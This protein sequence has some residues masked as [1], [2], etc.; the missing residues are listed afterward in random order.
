MKIKGNLKKMFLSLLAAMIFVALTGISAN[1]QTV[2]YS[3]LA[4]FSGAAVSNGGAAADPANGANLITRL[5]ADDLTMTGYGNITAFRF[6]VS[7]LGATAVSARPRVRF[8]QANGTNG[9]PGTLLGGY[10]FSAV[11]FQPGV[12]ILNTGA[13]GTPTAVNTNRIW[14]GITFDNN[15]GATG[16]TAADLN[17]LGMGV[18]NPPTVGS[19]TD[20]IF[21]TTSNGAFFADNPLGA[22]TNFGGNPVANLGWEIT[23]TNPTASGVTVS[24]K[25]SVSSRTREFFRGVVTMTDINGQ[26]RTAR[27]D[28]RGYFTFTDVPSGQV[29]IFNVVSRDY[30]FEPQSIY[31]TENLDGLNFTVRR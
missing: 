21:I 22:Q 17:N 13:L 8:Y 29:Y 2:V 1:A 27:A 16:A 11:T 25:V 31:V 12:T 19:S 26:T 18:Y 5:I 7:N 15:A 30:K 6:A 10:S 9:G 14:A 3:N 23:I 24:G 4:N 28:A 20:N